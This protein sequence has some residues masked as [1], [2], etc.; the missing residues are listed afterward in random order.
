M[1]DDN[2]IELEKNKN[3]LVLKFSKPYVFE[4]ESFTQIDLSGLE[5]VNAEQM[6][7]TSK[8]L[9]KQG[10]FSILPEMTLE[11]ACF[12]ASSVTGKPVEFFRQLPA[13]EAMKL[14]NRVQNFIYG[15]D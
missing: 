2:V 5:N 15:E 10:S 6:I 7:A 3:N 12:M 9:N 4:G 13:K 1:K 11:Y 8:Y 14:K